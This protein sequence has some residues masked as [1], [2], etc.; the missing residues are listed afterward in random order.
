MKAG[1]FRIVL[2]FSLIAA[3]ATADEGWKSLFDGRSLAGWTEAGGEGSFSV[4]DGM[5]VARGKPM[6]HLFYS[7]KVNGGDFKNFELKIKVQTKAKANGGVYFHTRFQKQGWPKHGIEAQV[8]ATHEDWRKSG[9]LYSILDVKDVAP[10][11]DDVWW[12]YHISVIGEHAV[13]KING[14][15]TA[16]WTQPEDWKRG[17]KRIDHGT[18][19]LQAHDPDSVVWFKD[20]QVKILP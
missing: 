5:I 12:D 6:G 20:I 2:A 7:G 3:V 13:V 10:H 19:A 11:T 4:R 15:T 1:A 17:P 16:E 14:K 9:S 18:F 8:N